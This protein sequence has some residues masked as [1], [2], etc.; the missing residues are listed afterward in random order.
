MDW[1]D[2]CG[3]RARG[4]RVPERER[5]TLNPGTPSNIR[6]DV[7]LEE[8]APRDNSPFILRAS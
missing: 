3:E 5:P 6:V 2:S 4:E 1:P 8:Q 7:A